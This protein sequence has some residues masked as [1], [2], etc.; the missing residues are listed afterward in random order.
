MA[1]EATAEVRAVARVEAAT[2]VAMAAVVT[3]AA[4]AAVVKVV[5]MAVEAKVVAMAAASPSQRTHPL[6][7]HPHQY[8]YH[9]PANRPVAPCPPAQTI[10]ASR[11]VCEAPP[12][13]RP[14]QAGCSTARRVVVVVEEEEAAWL[15]LPPPVERYA[16]PEVECPTSR[17]QLAR[18]ALS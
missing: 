14:I 5:A 15:R 3:A 10:G 7:R 1:V 17:D 2:A 18:V 16:R 12:P 9:S 13:L 11:R 8:P 6:H 4:M